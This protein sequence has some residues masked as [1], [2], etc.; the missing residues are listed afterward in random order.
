[1]SVCA[2]QSEREAIDYLIGLFYHHSRIRLNAEKDSL[3]RAR[4]GKRLRHYG[5]RNLV[6]YCHFLGQDAGRF[7]ITHAVDALATNRL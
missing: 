3:I 6:E 5:F 7:E 2:V 4:L 1:M